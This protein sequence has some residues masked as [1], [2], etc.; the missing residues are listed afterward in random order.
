MTIRVVVWMPFRTVPGGHQVQ[1]EGTVRAL[2]EL[3]ADVQTC[4]G[5]E[6]GFIG[7]RPDVVHG[8]GLTTDHVRSARRQGLPVALSTIYWSRRYT[9]RGAP[10]RSYDPALRRLRATVVLARGLLADTYPEKIDE[11]ASGLRTAAALFES[12]DLLLPNSSLE[13][14]AI[15][16]ELGVTTPCAVVP[17]AVDP[18]IFSPEPGEP[19]GGATTVLMVG[20]FEPHKNQLAL[21]RALAGS[22]LTLC[23]VGPAHPGHHAYMARC[24]KAAAGDDV[25]IL[26]GASQ[27]D[28]VG[29]YRSAAVHALPSWFETTGLVSLEAALCG[30]AIVT[31][32]RGYA[33][34]YFGDD[35]AYC[36]PD[37]LRSIRSA[38]FEALESGP[39]PGLQSRIR[40]RFTWRQAGQATLEAYRSVVA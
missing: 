30:S 33:S 13:L 4:F 6:L 1:C 36:R 22:G 31:T 40:R 27:Q 25:R 17:N 2:R 12:A 38:V 10:V 5:P 14:R 24:Q 16:E 39:A 34:E 29:L 23:L 21:I 32:S 15:R 7:S 11:Y 9:A 28:L 26:P 19:A 37:D 18:S 20:R 35:A 8:F 3:G